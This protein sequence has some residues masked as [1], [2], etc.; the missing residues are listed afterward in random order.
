MEDKLQI[1]FMLQ[2][3]ARI[4]IYS[5]LSLALEDFRKITLRITKPP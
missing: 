3:L 4:E 2:T 5:A 1:S